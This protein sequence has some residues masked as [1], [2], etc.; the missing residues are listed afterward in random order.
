MIPVDLALVHLLSGLSW[1]APKWNI[2]NGTQMGSQTWRKTIGARFLPDGS[3]LVKRPVDLVGWST[4]NRAWN[5]LVGVTVM[6]SGSGWKDLVSETSWGHN[7]EILGRLIHGNKHRIGLTHMD[8]KW[9]IHGLN[10]VGSLYFHQLHFMTLN[11]EIQWILKP[12]IWDPKPVSFACRGTHKNN[13]N[14]YHP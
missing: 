8:I 1:N 5:C 14:C 13:T 11:S 3:S 10:G 9:L 7:V 4:G 2:M 12:H 6:K